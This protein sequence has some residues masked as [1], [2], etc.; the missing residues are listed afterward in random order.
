MCGSI[1]SRMYVIDLRHNNRYR[2]KSHDESGV[3]GTAFGYTMT[4]VYTPETRPDSGFFRRFH[5]VLAGLRLSPAHQRTLIWT[6]AALRFT[7]RQSSFRDKNSRT[8][9][10]PG[11]ARG[12]SSFT[13]PGGKNQRGLVRR[14]PRGLQT[15]T[16]ALLSSVLKQNCGNR[17]LFHFSLRGQVAIS[18]HPTVAFS[19][20]RPHTAPSLG[21][22]QI[23]QKQR[24]SARVSGSSLI[25]KR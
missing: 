7:A 16:M 18:A 5:E 8:A 12:R 21:M 10:L 17:I 1:C 15:R 4:L 22:R 3:C 2:L 25:T 19:H 11:S 14:R 24:G 20:A 6:I 9:C 23:E 13:R